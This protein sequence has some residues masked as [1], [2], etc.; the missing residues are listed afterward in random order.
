MKIFLTGGTGFVGSHVLKELLERGHRI[1]A[2]RRP[3][4][5]PKLKLSNQ[6]D[7]TDGTLDEL[8]K[9]IFQGSDALVHLAAHSANVPYDSLEA[10]LY[11]NFQTS[12]N[13]VQQA[14]DEGVRRFLIAGTC[15]EYG[16]SGQRD[17]FIPSDAP[18]EPYES[19]P[20][21]KAVASVA[22]MALARMRSLSLSYH[23]IFQVYGEGE[24]ESRFWPS[25][26]KA[27]ARGEDFP[28]SP[29]QQVRDFTPVAVVAKHFAESLEGKVPPLGN[30]IALNVGTGVP[31]TLLAFAEQWWQRFGAT[32]RLLPGALPQRPSEVMRFVPLLP[33]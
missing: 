21:S 28:M 20:I 29:G 9:G 31:T 12:L 11:W 33:Q 27:A 8:P 6:P 5:E 18:L 17:E 24:K 15:F 19:Y 16:L 22:L 14:A 3:G 13:L 4:G 25:L 23:R 26:R 7:W 10:C 32:G 30:P 2:F 1:T